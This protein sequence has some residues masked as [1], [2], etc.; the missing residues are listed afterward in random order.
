MEIFPTEC[1][2]TGFS[3]ANFIGGAVSSFYALIPAAMHSVGASFPIFAAGY[4]LLAVAFLLL[5]ETIR[6][7]L[8]EL[9]G[10]RAGVSAQPSLATETGTIPQR[11][12]TA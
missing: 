2:A 12:T 4:A 8:I 1:R 9:V 3:V 7:E 5:N 10:Q 6:D 11:S